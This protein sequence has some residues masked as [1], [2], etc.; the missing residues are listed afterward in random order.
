MSGSAEGQRF[1]RTQE[2][3]QVQP[4]TGGMAKGGVNAVT[5]V[6][7]EPRQPLALDTAPPAERLTHAEQARLMVQ[8]GFPDSNTPR[9][10]FL[11]HFAKAAEIE[12]AAREVVASVRPCRSCDLRSIT[13]QRCPVCRLRAL[14]QP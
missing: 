5:W 13:S 2:R 7:P 12:R 11:E 8:R 1:G 10:A 3:Q 6:P 4:L 14:V 9:A